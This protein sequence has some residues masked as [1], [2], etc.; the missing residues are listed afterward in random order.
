MQ[1][2]I[3]PA[4]GEVNYLEALDIAIEREIK[5]KYMYETLAKYV[6][7]EHM[8]NKLAFLASEEQKH[9]DKGILEVQLLP[10]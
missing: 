6:K 8:K 9:R 10:A 5:A 2:K 1:Q 7:T 3:L 4:Q